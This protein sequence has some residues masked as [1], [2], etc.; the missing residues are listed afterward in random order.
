MSERRSRQKFEPWHSFVSLLCLWFC[1]NIFTMAFHLLRR[2]EHSPEF[3]LSIV[4]LLL[5]G[6]AS[7]YLVRE[8][9]IQAR[10][11]LRRFKRSK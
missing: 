6:A 3:A 5:S 10:L 9:L 2:A 8:L 11:L 1:A 7:I 4:F